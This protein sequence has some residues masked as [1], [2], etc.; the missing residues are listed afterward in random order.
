MCLGISQDKNQS[1]NDWCKKRNHEP[2]GFSRRQGHA[3][4][5]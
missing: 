5:G 3:W 2:A 4:E 1:K